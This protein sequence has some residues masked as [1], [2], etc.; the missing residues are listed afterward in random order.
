MR[1]FL[2]VLLDRVPAFAKPF[3]V[4]IPVLRNDGRDALRM[5]ECQTES[6]GCTVIENVNR[7]GFETDP[8]SKARDDHRQM[9][10]GVVE[11]LAVR[12]IRESETRQIGSDYV[13]TIG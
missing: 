10:E 4:G 2:P 3:F 6:D 12:R 9:I 8:V 7:E 13:I 5:G 1:R 11:L